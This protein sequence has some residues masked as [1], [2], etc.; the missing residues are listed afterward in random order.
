MPC[1]PK[2]VA[3][4]VLRALA[5]LIWGKGRKCKCC[6]DQTTD[7]PTTVPFI[8]KFDDGSSK[9]VTFPL[10][11]SIGGLV[12][13]LASCACGTWAVEHE[14]GVGLVTVGGSWLQPELSL[15]QCNIQDG[16]ILS[17]RPRGMLRGGAKDKGKREHSAAEA[18]SEAAGGEV[19]PDGAATGR[20]WENREIT[21][22][23]T[24]KYLAF[25]P[26]KGGARSKQGFCLALGARGRGIP[27]PSTRP[28]ASTKQLMSS[29]R[30]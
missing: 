11:E 26:G 27:S 14:R 20:S 6:S 24:V 1:L 30:R 19:L 9:G 22:P 21:K 15:R 23:I 16:C 5:S 12:A 28:G 25:A 17:L 18:E 10:D 2:F 3:A 4:A 13:S 8:V 7:K 29:S